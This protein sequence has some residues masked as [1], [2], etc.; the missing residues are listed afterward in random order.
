MKLEV[1]LY[2]M[3]LDPVCDVLMTLCIYAWSQREQAAVAGI[4][5][6]MF[7]AG[8]MK[9]IMYFDYLVDSRLF[10]PHHCHYFSH[11][12]CCRYKGFRKC[13]VSFSNFL[14]ERF[15]DAKVNRRQV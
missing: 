12:F 13:N 14:L 9:N 8:V 2:E 1:K 15:G 3:K 11:R 6:K 4:V 7:I 5:W 10:F